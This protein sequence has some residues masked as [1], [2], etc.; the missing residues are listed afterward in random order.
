M[1]DELEALKGDKKLPLRVIIGRTLKYIRTERKSFI[2]ALFLIALNVFLDTISPLFTS[3]ITDEPVIY[4]VVD[5]EA[6]IMGYVRLL[7]G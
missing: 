7:E 3:K 2:F 5:H 6:G 1:N 4:S